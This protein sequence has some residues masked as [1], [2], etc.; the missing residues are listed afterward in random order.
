MNNLKEEMPIVGIQFCHFA[1]QIS[2]ESKCSLLLLCI[3]HHE[4]FYNTDTQNHVC[5]AESTCIHKLVYVS[6]LNLRCL[7]H[8]NTFHRDKQESQN[9]Q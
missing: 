6:G 7:E 4:T 1:P 3:M 8:V 2:R 9:N 5:I